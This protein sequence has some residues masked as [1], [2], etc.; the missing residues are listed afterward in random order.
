MYKVTLYLPNSISSVSSVYSNTALDLEWDFLAYRLSAG[1]FRLHRTS[2]TYEYCETT[3]GSAE[4][5]SIKHNMEAQL[6]LELQAVRSVALVYRQ[7]AH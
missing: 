2:T 6:D 7:C 1:D 4:L 5:N 3:S